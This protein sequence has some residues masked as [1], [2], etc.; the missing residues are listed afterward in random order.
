[1]SEENNRTPSARKKRVRMLKR[2]IILTL[3][4][5]IA[6]PCICCVILFSKVHSLEQALQTTM[7]RLEELNR[8]QE[9]AAF[10]ETESLEETEIPTVD[11]SVSDEVNAQS[12][13]PEGV[14]KV[15]LTFDDGFKYIY[16]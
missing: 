11:D 9:E 4:L 1:M 6:T 13:E 7:S 3:I 8:T 12:K 14:R 16:R 10:A 5:S 2:L 15:Y